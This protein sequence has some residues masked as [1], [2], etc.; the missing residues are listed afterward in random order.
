MRTTDAIADAAAVQTDPTTMRAVTHATYGG[1]ETLATARVEVPTPGASQVLVAVTAAGIDRG[2]WHLVTG[3]PYLVRLAG[4]GVRAPKQPIPGL[5][6]AGRVVAVGSDVTRFRPGDRVFGIGSGAYAEYALAEQDKLS[7]TPDTITDEQAAVAAISGGPALQAVTD[8][9][10]VRHGQRVLVIGASGGVGSYAVQLAV[11]HGA[12]VTGVSSAAKADL[13][14]QLGA[15]HVV[16]YDRDELD[17]EGVAYD[18]VVSTGGLAPVRVLRRLL[19]PTGTLVIVGAEGG[20]AITGGVGRQLRALLWSP[21]VGQRLTALMAREHHD[22]IDR[23]AA[24]LA[25]GSVAPA[26]GRTVTLDEV[27]ETL[28]TLESGAIRGK[29]VVRIWDG[30]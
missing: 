28:A 29:A 7:H 20:G 1:P 23:L 11:A 4:S 30:A 18:L 26:I 10:R 21:F 3:R 24:H 13:V 15:E 6:L 27:P 25:D 2:V 8:I 5:D 12:T 9:G 17:A 19:T 22:V 16:A 14:R